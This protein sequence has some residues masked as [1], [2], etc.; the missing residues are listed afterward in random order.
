MCSLCG[1]L[2]GPDH[3]TDAVARPGVFS[4]S[5]DPA[6]RRRERVRRVALANR[7]L[8][9]FGMELSDWQGSSFLLSTRT[10]KTAIVSDLAHLWKE[11]E[12]LSGRTCDP[13]DPAFLARCEAVRG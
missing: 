9:H 10:G 7:V 2:G 12:T 11:A 1:V 4:R 13:L 5:P 6:S 3:W 8:R